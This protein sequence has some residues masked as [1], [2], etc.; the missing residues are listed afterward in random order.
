MPDADVCPN[1]GSHYTERY[2]GMDRLGLVTFHC[3]NCLI[4]FDVDVDVGEAE[5]DDDE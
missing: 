3:F 2:S 5:E 4:D 1:C